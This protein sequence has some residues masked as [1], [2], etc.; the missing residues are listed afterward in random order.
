MVTV[1]LTCVYLFIFFFSTHIWEHV[2]DK[3]PLLF[4]GDNKVFLILI[5]DRYNTVE[6]RNH[7]W[8][9]FSS[10]PQLCTAIN[11][12]SNSR[13]L[14]LPIKFL[15]STEASVLGQVWLKTCGW[16]GRR[17]G[18]RRRRRRRGRRPTFMWAALKT[19]ILLSPSTQTILSKWSYHHR[20][21][22]STMWLEIIVRGRLSTWSQD[23][24]FRMGKQSNELLKAME[25]HFLSGYG[26]CSLSLTAAIILLFA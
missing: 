7:V 15:S 9:R 17:R 4:T 5:L 26:V 22:V 6:V 19:I 3:F 24:A 13:S 25:T 8:C 20:S 16:K 2:K 11:V 12:A 10:E 1:F 21:H 14:P 23:E 18:R